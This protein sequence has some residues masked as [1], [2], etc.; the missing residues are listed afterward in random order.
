MHPP[1][2]VCIADSRPSPPAASDIFDLAP[3]DIVRQSPLAKVE[4]R[5]FE[6][7]ASSGF[8]LLGAGFSFAPTTNRNEATYRGPVLRG[9]AAPL[10]SRPV[11]TP[12]NILQEPARV[13][14]R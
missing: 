6:R 4:K 3:R 9:S 10:E 2:S 1:A 5:R 13:C 11:N 8:E 12:T 7:P 14:A